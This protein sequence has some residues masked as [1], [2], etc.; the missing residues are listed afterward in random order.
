MGKIK[1]LLLVI[2]ILTS[3]LG[4]GQ[5]TLFSDNFNTSTGAAWD[6]ASYIGTS[7]EWLV[8]IA[9]GTD[10]ATKIDGNLLQMTNDRSATGNSNG[11]VFSWR[12]P[13]EANGFSKTLGNSTG[14]VI[15]EFNMRQITTNPAGFGTN[16]YGVAFILGGTEANAATV[17]NGYAVVL[18]ESGTTDPLRLI[19]YTGGLR[20][21]GTNILTSNTSG[22]TDF[23]NNYLSVRVTYTPG[24]NTW[25]LFVRNDGATGFTDPT[26][27]T[28]LVSQ[29]TATD[30]TYTS[31]AL[32]YQGG[33]WQGS[34]TANQT[35]FFDNFYHKI[36]QPPTSPSFS[37]GATTICVGGT[38][39]YTA[40]ATGGTSVTYSILSGGASINSS[41]GV[42]SSVVSNFTVRATI[43]NACGSSTTVDR[44]VT[45]NSPTISYVGSP[46]QYTQNTA[47]ANLTPTTTGT[48]FS[49]TLPT[50]LSINSTNG[51]ISGTPTGT[52]T[53]TN[54]TITATANGCSNTTS[55]SIAV[56]PSNDLCSSATSLPCTTSSLAGTTVGSLSETAPGTCLLG[57]GY[58]VWYTFTGD[59]QQTTISVTS[60]TDMGLYVGSGNCTTRTQISCVDANGTNSTETTTFTTTNGTVYYVYV[61]YYGVSVIT[62]T[63]TISRTCVTP[64][65]P[66]SSITPIS[67]GGSNSFTIASGSGIYNPPSTT[68]GF[69]TPGKEY[70]FS[71]TPTTT[72]NHLISQPTS[73]GYIDWFYKQSSGGCSGTG[74]TCIDDISNNNLGNSNVSIPL[75]A[76]VTYYFLADPESTTGG[77]VIF[78]ITCPCTIPTAGGTLSSNK[79][80]T[81]VNDAVS[82]T[83]SG[84]G[85]S[86][87]K[88][89]F[90][91][92][93]FTTIATSVN[94]PGNP[95]VIALNVQE[96]NVYVRTTSQ[97]GSCPVGVSNI[98]GIQLESAPTYSDGIVDGDHITNVT[99]SNINNNSTNDGDS[100]QN[101]LS[102]IIE[103]TTE[104]TYTLSTSATNTLNPGQGYAAWIDWDGDGTFQT[105][106]NVMQKAPAATTSQSITVPIDAV[107]GD[108]K[109]RILSVWNATPS[110]DA[111]YSVGYGY[112]EI[113]EYT[114]RISNPISLPVE[115]ISFNAICYDE[116]VLVNWITASEYNT[117][118]FNLE[119]SRNGID[120]EIIHT[121]QAAENSTQ[122]ITYGFM[123]KNI[124][125][126]ANYYR[127]NQYDLDGV[128]EQ[129]GPISINCLQTTNGYFSVF[130]NPSSTAFSVIVNNELLIGDATLLITNDMGKEIYTKNIKV[131]P[132]I[133]LF[134]I[135]NLDVSSGVYYIS[136]I[137]S[138]H[139]SGVLKHVIR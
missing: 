46:Y 18:G 14:T 6:N 22:L 68:C 35:A 106:E 138:Y 117:S 27:G 20:G 71:F 116:K 131:L 105:T 33:Y 80:E 86:I 5:T 38:S 50:G 23:G 54:Y 119:K 16:T 70:L 59:G 60:A 137:N 92:D 55:I 37:A 127:L 48:S 111:Y 113:E 44:S 90:S 120:W 107:I 9:A 97:D 88:I 17:G 47:I 82:L 91:Y 28:A 42:V 19:R 115:L 13:S 79:S 63:F 62:G 78:S 30:N 136:I 36:C 31:T 125:N 135:E 66:C 118:H 74:W 10:F 134:N 49:A 72:G 100:Y 69:S 123:D 32:S 64:Y 43:S 124:F 81:V 39:T 12:L 114:V 52:Q 130:P 76:G 2:S 40:S 126:D 51:V 122:L 96:S 61:A 104:E 94:N 56:R 89:E 4:L 129:F 29:G 109:M 133:K 95:Y 132:G 110:T 24:S 93:N 101:F 21:T 67:C 3:F 65:N 26:T 85:G 99:L 58:G 75:T 121:E 11:W 25:Q 83:T 57:G 53:A 128:Y 87:T 73:F 108:T 7:T 34:T 77:N 103:L 84:N 139:T 15:W 98:V 41:T 112:G 8:N 1:K 102:L 45:V